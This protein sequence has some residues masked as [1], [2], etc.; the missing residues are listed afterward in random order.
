M[1]SNPYSTPSSSS[2]PGSRNAQSLVR[3]PALGLIVVSCICILVVALG[4]LFSGYLLVS[5]TAARLP[6]PS[7]G[8]T[9]G[10][11]I[12]VRMTWS[13]ILLCSNSIVL[14]GSLKM[15]KVRSYSFAKAASIISL[16]PCIGPCYVAG[17]P[18]GIWALV[19]LGKP[20]VKAAFRETSLNSN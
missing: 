5:G 16:I 15:L 7:I 6:Q 11:Q 1:T 14:A 2:R 3:G 4:L 9:K 17:I 10:S 13:V 19:V 12:M 20:E 8:M 18:F